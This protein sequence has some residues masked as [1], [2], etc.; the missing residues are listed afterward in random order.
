M[1]DLN[2]K[3]DNLLTLFDER[4]IATRATNQKIG[5][6]IA[7]TLFAAIYALVG[8]GEDFVDWTG[9]DIISDTL[10][11]ACTLTYDPAQP[12]T[13]VLAKLDHTLK[14]SDTPV[15]I[16]RQVRFGLPLSMALDSMEEI[17]KFL[18][19]AIVEEPTLQPSTSSTTFV[20]DM[21]TLS[22]EQV[23]QLAFSKQFTP[24]TRQ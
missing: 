20:F 9:M 11:V 8:L 15:I 24:E 13:E 12:M 16:E 5:L 7:P 2:S 4:E 17:A 18:H 3:M 19:D 23:E 1:L 10:V 21:T 22:K 14:Q 6:L